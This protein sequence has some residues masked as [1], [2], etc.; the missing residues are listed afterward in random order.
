MA[1][2]SSVHLGRRLNNAFW[3]GDQMAY[4]DGDGLLF[5]G[6]TRALDVVAHE[7]THGVVSHTSNLEYRNEPGA[8]NEHFADVMGILVRQWRRRQTAR[9]ADWRIGVAIMGPGVTAR[10]LRT[11]TAAKAYENDPVLGTDTQAPADKYRGPADSGV[12]IAP[13][14]PTR[15]LPGRSDDR[16]RA[17]SARPHLVPDAPRPHPPQRV[18]RRGDD[19][20]PDRGG[21][22]REGESGGA[23][24][25]GGV[26]GRRV[27]TGRAA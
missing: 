27:V 25:A 21:R 5:R 12:H 6:F 14:S 17:W 15:V 23:G 7:L 24:G 16:R 1:L 13:G 10:C 22:V 20:H 9:Q 11:F 26:E 2:V 8:L 4:G 19:H 18:Q 3:T